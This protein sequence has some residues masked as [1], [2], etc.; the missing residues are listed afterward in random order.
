MNQTNFRTAF[1][2]Q[3]ETLRQ[4][5]GETVPLED[6]AGVVEALMT[7][8]EGDISAVDI[9]LHREIQDLLGYLERVRGEIAAIQPAKITEDHIAVA[10]DELDAVV[11]ATEDATD[12]ILDAAEELETLGQT[13]GDEAGEQIAEITA[14]I[15][16]ASNFQ[17]ITGQRITKVVGAIQHIENKILL[18]AQSFGDQVGEPAAEE[19]FGGEPDK[20]DERSLLNGPQL[21]AAA[22]SQEDIDALLAS[23]D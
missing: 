16:A 1:A 15:Y 9:Q 17:D 22:N 5:C 13:L 18:L 6:V 11:K 10:A 7:T 12:S 14:R 4:D 23:F 2:Q 20:E 8:A 21:P 19:R 3:V